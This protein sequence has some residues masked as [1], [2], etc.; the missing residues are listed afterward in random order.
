MKRTLVE[1][2]PAAPLSA[3]KQEV[4]RNTRDLRMFLVDRM[5]EV[6]KREIEP[7]QVTGI[8]NLAQQIYNTL[9]IELKAAI[10]FEKLQGE[11]IKAVQFDE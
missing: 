1:R 6:V 2:Q 10:V 5:K 4:I 7:V 11:E 8:A 3:T 9:N